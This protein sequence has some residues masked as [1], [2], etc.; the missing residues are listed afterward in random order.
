[1]QTYFAHVWHL[2][3]L[4]RRKVVFFTVFCLQWCFLIP[5]VKA[6]KNL[7]Q[8]TYDR[9]KPKKDINLP[10]YD[11]KK[12]HYGF[13]L[14]LNYSRLEITH[15]QQFIQDTAVNSITPMGVQIGRAHV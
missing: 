8:E 9:F 4:H 5:N 6:Q 7:S 10:L 3:Y 15:S 12:I 14:G 1:M 2:L 13:F 11:E